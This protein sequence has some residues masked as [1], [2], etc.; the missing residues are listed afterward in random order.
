VS[1]SLSASKSLTPCS[2][3]SIRESF[4]RDRRPP[5]ADSFSAASSKVSPLRSR[6]CRSVS[7]SCRNRTV[8]FTGQSASWLTRPPIG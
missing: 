3:F 2:R 8:G 7:V 6:N 1:S 4:D 5:I